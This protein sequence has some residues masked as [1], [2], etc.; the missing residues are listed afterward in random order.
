MFISLFFICLLEFCQNT[1]ESQNLFNGSK[2][3]YDSYG[4][5][6]HLGAR[7]L[8]SNTREEVVSNISS[9]GVKMVRSD[10]YWSEIQN[11]YSKD[12][13]YTHIDELYSIIERNDLKL[14]PILDYSIGEFEDVW[15][16]TKEW[17]DYVKG[18]VE[19]Y[20]DFTNCWEIW[21]EE[22]HPLFWKGE[23]SCEQY[24]KILKEAS[25]IIHDI[26]P[27]SLILLGGMAGVDEKYLSGLFKIG[28]DDYFDIV[29]F[30]YY[31]LFEPELLIPQ[32]KKLKK[33]LDENNCKKKVWLTEI[34]FSTYP[35][36]QLKLKNQVSEFFQASSLPK[37]FLIAYS[38]GIEKVFWY[39]Y[40]TEEYNEQNSEHYY[41][42]SH[43]DFT[44]K[45]AFYA[46]KVLINMLPDGASRP[47]LIREGDFYTC[48]WETKDGLGVK[49]CWS[50]NGK[51]KRILR[52][53]ECYDLYGKRLRRRYVTIS[54]NILYFVDNG[55]N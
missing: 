32:L 13:N 14:L 27:S 53:G 26:S 48:K 22:N 20:K 54:N 16:H 7:N 10:L 31:P 29:N 42:I 51:E 9:L 25:R 12:K 2:Y 37:I 15:N 46:Y 1:E 55:K 8:S 38:Y 5:C 17:G 28:A 3:L 4:L 39:C 40:Q 47:S 24:Y 34:G 45:K 41:G 36:K 49:A 6:A 43:S 35:N 23:P 52:K 11:D 50:V 44:P 18:V 21:N 33:I 19:R 30:H